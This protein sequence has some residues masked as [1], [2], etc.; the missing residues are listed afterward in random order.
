MTERHTVGKISSLFYHYMLANDNSLLTLRDG[1]NEKIVM[2]KDFNNFS[3]ANKKKRRH[4]YT[5]HIITNHDWRKNR[6]LSRHS[7]NGTRKEAFTHTRFLS[8]FKLP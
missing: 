7:V 3:D 1:E 5:K 6:I 4:A 2:Q 8:L